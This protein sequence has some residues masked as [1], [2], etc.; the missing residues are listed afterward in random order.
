[1]TACAVPTRLAGLSLLLAAA[2]LSGGCEEDSPTEV[3]NAEITLTFAPDPIGA[4][5]SPVAGFEWRAS[6]TLTVSETEGVGGTITAV[7]T[8]LF[9]AAGGIIIGT[10]DQ[11]EDVAVSAT[12]GSNRL[13]PRGATT[14]G[15]TVDYRLPGDH[16][17]ALVQVTVT[18]EDDNDQVV[19]DTESVA[20]L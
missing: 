1:M 3:D 9:E 19:S 16:R 2:A 12:A 18:V 13:E 20:V 11:D 15:F 4:Q 8:T 6:F 14:I 10:P 17:E 5:P 7:S